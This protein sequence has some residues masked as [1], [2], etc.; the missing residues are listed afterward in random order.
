MELLSIILLVI[1][2][3][4]YIVILIPVLY[5]FI[6]SAASLFFT[7]KNH[8]I[9]V[10]EKRPV[11]VIFPAYQE[12]N[13]ILNSAVKAIK[14]KSKLAKLDVLVIAD[15]LQ[16]ATVET[17]RKEGI[18]V[19]EFVNQQGTKAAA[20]DF[21]MQFIPERTEEIVILDIDNVMKEGFIDHILSSKIASNL[22]IVQGHRTAKNQNT[23]YAVLDAISEEVNNS[24]LRRGHEV[25]GLSSSVIGSGF[26]ADTS[27]FREEFSGKVT[28][29]GEDK[30]FELRLLRKGIRIGYDDRAIVYDEKVQRSE[31]FYH[32]RK[33]WMAIQRD[34]KRSE[35]K[36][37]IKSFEHICNID[38]IDKVYQLLI[39]PKII[40][41]GVIV[42]GTLLT[43][44][45]TIF[46][47][48]G[49]LS[50]IQGAWIFLFILLVITSITS[51]PFKYIKKGMALKAVIHLPG[52]LLLMIRARLNLRKIGTDFI[53]TKHEID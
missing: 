37:A 29:R 43:T 30:E 4:I 15:G 32:Q 5:F 52:V 25:L 46:M 26:I 51:F 8:T 38:Y 39:P 10:T 7:Q 47:Q 16:P 2:L 18:Q 24:I 3:I 27:L 13:V 36:K 9:K 35:V 40:I 44:L 6:F 19:E 1:N 21:A 50:L 23:A 48:C 14:H 45:L 33:R 49:M 42:A 41:I 22:R 12:D 11:T 20:L 31:S 17:L 28:S 53:H 34:L